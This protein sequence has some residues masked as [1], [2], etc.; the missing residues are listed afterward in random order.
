[1]PRRKAESERDYSVGRNQYLKGG[2]KM[3]GLVKHLA[4]E[5]GIDIEEAK[6]IYEERKNF[7]KFF[8]E[9][10]KDDRQGVDPEARRFNRR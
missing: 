4:R 7:N 2:N 10:N 1:L 8:K 9:V 3:N 5:K 6:N